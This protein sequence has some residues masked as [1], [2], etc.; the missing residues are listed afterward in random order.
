MGAHPSDTTPP[1]MTRRS[2][3]CVVDQ[4]DSR[5]LPAALAVVLGVL[6]LAADFI[7]PT[8]GLVLGAAAVL[9]GSAGAR[10]GTSR[11]ART[12]GFIGVGLGILAVLV[13]VGLIVFGSGSSG[14][15]DSLVVSPPPA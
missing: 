9:L 8:I 2:L 14:G 6:G 5:A 1:S 4:A 11:S 13:V 10:R 7:F 15:S 12:A 3:H